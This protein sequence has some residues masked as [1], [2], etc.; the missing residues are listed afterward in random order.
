[1][2]KSCL[3]KNATNCIIGIHLES[4]RTQTGIFEQQ[5]EENMEVQPTCYLF[6]TDEQKEYL[7]FLNE[8]DEN[9][10]A[11]IG[12]SNSMKVEVNGSDEFYMVT[13]GIE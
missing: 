6:R 7:D 10:Y 11:I 13:Y 2:D 9:Q 8:F 12:I 5:G 4:T 3:W 1:M